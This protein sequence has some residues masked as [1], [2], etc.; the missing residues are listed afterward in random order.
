MVRYAEAPTA[1]VEITVATSPAVVWPH[2]IDIDLPARF[3]P[4]FQGAEWLA[5]S[6][7]A[8]GATFE[9]HNKHAAV[10]EWTTTSTVT[11][12]EPERT[13]E[14]TVGDLANK[15]ARWR[16]DLEPDGTGCRL[17]FSAEMGP[18]PSGL[19]GAIAAMPDREEEIV[20]RRVQEWQRNMSL[21]IEGIKELAETA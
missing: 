15:T 3:S 10:G 2:V 8:L 9:G 13:F 19:S 5:G 14:W 18:G 20:D 16:F 1:S 21:T 17:R 12:F 6:G 7:P 11:A 4:E